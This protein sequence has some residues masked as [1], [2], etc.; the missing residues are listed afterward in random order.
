[1]PG[2]G[3]APK[4]PSQRR[5]HIAPARGEWIE[6]PKPSLEPDEIRLRALKPFERAHF[7]PKAKAKWAVWRREPV[8]I[9][10]SESDIDFALATL[11]LY[12]CSDWTRHAAEIR[13]REDRLALTPKGKR[14][15]RFK[16]MFGHGREASKDRPPPEA[17]NVVH[18]DERLRNLHHNGS[19]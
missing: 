13:L 3:A 7:T 17:D 15:N 11:E 4:H 18:L 9:Y 2:V 5:N 19:A 14:D 1:M 16:I 10:W 12:S 6:L 8:T